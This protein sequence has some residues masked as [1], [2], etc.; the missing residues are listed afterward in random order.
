MPLIN[1]LSNLPISFLS[2]W[3]YVLILLATLLESTPLFGLFI[4][5]QVLLTAAGFAAYQGILDIGDLLFFAIIGAIFGDFV[6][7]FLGKKYGYSL[8][9]R[10]G[11]YLFIKKEYFEKT[12]KLFEQHPGK[13]LL[14]GRF[15]SLT[16]AFAS[17]VAG[18]TD[19]SFFKFLFYNI[20]GGICWVSVFVLGGYIFGTSYTAISQY[21]GRF[22]LV[23]VLL[24]IGILYLYRLLNKKK[25]IFSKQHFLFLMLNIFSIFLFSKLM[26]DVI[27]GELV[28]H[29]D[30]LA[31]TKIASLWN[32]LITKI[33][34]GLT[35]LASPEVLVALSLLLALFFFFR[36][37]KEASALLTFSML[38]AL[39]LTLLFKEI[40]QRA[41]PLDGLIAESGY[42]FP[43]GHATI[44]TVFFCFLMYTFYD[45]IENEV[46]QYLFV[47][48]NILLILLVGFSRLYL[49]VHWFSDVLAGFCLGVGWFTLVVL[50]MRIYVS[51]RKRDG[52]KYF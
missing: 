43:S 15:N 35:T 20:I 36:Q 39:T 40:V 50:G 38:G 24:S 10:Y 31:Y 48:G 17:F 49:H 4:P 1:T 6:G 23:G 11:K 14:F 18:A 16:R 47:L 8:I 12:K 2:N 42:S 45:Q 13:T 7:Y 44:A 19:L 30:S 28:V 37:K 46:L 21:I 5:G 9:T 22:F 25:Q 29:F 32:P 51:S 26:E 34:I 33:M 41:R 27:D 52:R 3:G